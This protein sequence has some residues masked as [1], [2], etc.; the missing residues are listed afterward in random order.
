M[1]KT[2]IQKDLYKTKVDA[3]FDRFDNGKLYYNVEIMGE[4]YQFPINT[5]E[6]NVSDTTF[7]YIIATDIKGAAFRTQMPARELFRWIAK[8]V[9]SNDLIKLSI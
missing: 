3:T 6:K 1:N 9:D 4:P 5:L 2:D 8:A 7:V